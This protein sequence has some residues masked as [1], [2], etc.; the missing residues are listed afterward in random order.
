M[1]HR[2]HVMGNQAYPY[3]RT[4][5]GRNGMV[6]DLSIA[7]L[8]RSRDEEPIQTLRDYQR[9][10]TC[11]PLI[12]ACQSSSIS[13]LGSLRLMFPQGTFLLFDVGLQP[14]TMINAIAKESYT[15]YFLVLWSDM[16]IVSDLDPIL[17]AWIRK[18]KLFCATPMIYDSTGELIASV[19]VPVFTHK[20]LSV[21]TM[22]PHVDRYAN[23]FPYEGVGIYDRIMFQ[24]IRGVDTMYL[25]LASQL[26]D[27]GAKVWMTGAQIR[28]CAGLMVTR[29]SS[30]SP[31]TPI[32]AIDTKRYHD[33]ILSIRKRFN[34]ITY[35]RR[36]A[37]RAEHEPWDLYD[38]RHRLVHDI[39]SLCRGWIVHESPLADSLPAPN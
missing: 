5:V 8:Q 35:P 19:S 12:Y 27:L 21:N 24:R 33:K 9:R 14:G 7:I 20:S 18:Q 31:Q 37:A 36:I 32:P 17:L 30:D 22:L 13:D 1:K 26:M 3:Q 23:F 29:T 16:R 28:N 4:S 38:L 39:P 25:S 15:D 11:F 10:F 6:N 34:R 2:Y